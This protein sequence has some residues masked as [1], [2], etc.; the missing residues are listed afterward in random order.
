MINFFTA[1]INRPGGTGRITNI[2]YSGQDGS[3]S[4][5]TVIGLDVK[6]TIYSGQDQHLDPELVKP[7]EELES[8]GRRRAPALIVAAVAS[9]NC[10]PS[11]SNRETKS[12][13][14]SSKRHVHATTKKCSASKSKLPL[15]R[16]IGLPI[17]RKNLQA[18]IQSATSRKCAAKMTALAPS[19][20]LEITFNTATAS[21]T[22]NSGCSKSANSLENCSPLGLAG[23]ESHL[24]STASYDRL[25]E[26]LRPSVGTSNAHCPLASKNRTNAACQHEEMDFDIVELRISPCFESDKT[27]PEFCINATPLASGRFSKDLSYFAED[28]KL[29]E[30]NDEAV[31]HLK[32]NESDQRVQPTLRDVFDN[33]KKKASQFVGDVVQD[34]TNEESGEST[35]YLSIRE[36]RLIRFRS[37]LSDVLIDSDGMIQSENIANELRNFSS[38]SSN[39]DAFDFTQHEVEAF[40]SELCTQNKI[41]QTEGWIY[42]I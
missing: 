33:E 16:K 19:I 20:P 30:K 26:P 8:R 6:Y 14:I 22:P 3:N 5:P 37:L 1:R 41:M 4:S 12:S 23:V 15:R 9:E 42:N 2:H 29:S 38:Q 18:A 31:A 21:N 17:R 7:H 35:K 36:N 39:D 10:I 27:I 25:T 34:Y 40:V 13:K 24:L 11:P 32:V 28:A